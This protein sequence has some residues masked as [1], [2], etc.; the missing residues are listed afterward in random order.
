MECNVHL[1]DHEGLR[2]IVVDRSLQLGALSMT[3]ASTFIVTFVLS[4]ALRCPSVIEPDG[5]GDGLDV[6]LT[7]P[8]QAFDNHGRAR[9]VLRRVIS[10]GADAIEPLQQ[11]LQRSDTHPRGRAVLMFAHGAIRAP[12][13]IP[14]LEQAIRTPEWATDGAFWLRAWTLDSPMGRAAHVQSRRLL[15]GSAEW[16]AFFAR[17]LDERP[18][19]ALADGAR[20]ALV[21][22]Q[23]FPS[24]R[25]ADVLRGQWTS[26]GTPPVQACVI[27]A[28]LSAAGDAAD[29]ALLRAAVA[30]VRGSVAAID[31]EQLVALG[32]AAITTRRWELSPLFMDVLDGAQ[33]SGEMSRAAM[34]EQALRQITSTSPGG[35]AWRAWLLRRAQEDHASRLDRHAA[36]LERVLDERLPGAA[37]LAREFL[38]RWQDPRLLDT[39]E[40]IAHDPELH[41]AIAGWIANVYAAQREADLRRLA[42][43]LAPLLPPDVGVRLLGVLDTDTAAWE[44]FVDAAY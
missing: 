43:R 25:A 28:H 7:S 36:L 41:A 3:I 9:P 26:G 38:A 33:R 4:S 2:R 12:E 17:L 5:D 21:V 1:P 44:R 18:Q 40:R 39:M 34:A 6:L 32:V 20:L 31:E 42:E 22:A 16:D 10:A 19:D 30:R 29:P 11:R 8:E 23:Y 27:F 15:R 24:G 14:W 35:P 37:D 13:S